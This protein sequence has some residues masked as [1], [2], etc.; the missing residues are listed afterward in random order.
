MPDL[1]DRHAR[2]RRELAAAANKG[3]L[4][5]QYRLTV[6]G[7][8]DRSIHVRDTRTGEQRTMLCFDSN[9]YLG[10]HLDPR[11]IRATHD[12]LAIAGYGT[13]SAQLLSGTNRWLRDLE[14][15]VADFHGREAALVFPSGYAANIGVMTALLRPG[16]AIVRDRFTHASVHDGARFARVRHGGCYAHRDLDDA[17]HLL[18]QCPTDAAKLVATDGVFSMHGTLAPL[19]DLT[20]LAKRHGARLLVD[21][22]H[23][24]G[25]LGPRGRGIEDYYGCVGAA[26]ILV[27]TFSKAPGTAGGYVTGS[28]D[29]ID[30]LRFHA[31]A[32]VFTAALPSAMC[33][34]IA[35]A[36]RIMSTESESRDRL[37]ANARRFHAGAR[38]LG[39]TTAPLESPIV[40]IPAGDDDRL[41]AISLALYEAGVKCGAVRSPAVPRGASILR[42]SINARHED[43]DIDRALAALDR[44]FHHRDAITGRA[45]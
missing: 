8:L 3:I 37:W 41:D 28:R 11:V 30:Y 12:V 35:T 42:F 24:T 25:V 29:L 13:P 14:D 6:E 9:S 45:A 1:F 7:P 2:F 33:A 40:P 20:R 5:S 16:D 32:S 21:D 19:S 36:F 39:L 4:D 38:D 44:A 10:L 23:G 22:A 15:I 26:D 18:E 43:E 17:A 34:G 27:G 31:H